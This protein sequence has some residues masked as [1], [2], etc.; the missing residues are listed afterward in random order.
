MNANASSMTATLKVA[1][2]T[3]RYWSLPSLASQGFPD[4][5]RLPRSIRV[6]LESVMRRMNTPGCTPETVRALVG[7]KPD[8]LPGEEIP[9][10]PSR[11]LLQ[12]FTGVPCVADL[13]ALR[14]ALH[15]RSGDPRRIEP[16]LPVDLVIDHSVQL[17]RAASPTAEVEN[18]RREFE[19]NEERYA[20]LR[21][22]QRA[23]QKLR[24]WPPGLG[25]C[26]QVNMEFLATVVATGTDEDGHAIAFPDTLVGTDSHTVMINSLGVM[27]WGVGG[28]EA[29]AAMLGQPMPL[30]A[31][32][33]TGVRVTGRLRL[34]ATATDAALVIT[35]MLRKK[36][37]VGH[38][39]EFFGPGLDT[40]NVFDRAPMANMAPEYGATMGFFPIDGHT[41]DYLRDTGRAPEQVALVEAYARAQGLWRDSQQPDPEFTDVVELNLSAIEPSVAGPKRPQD[42]KRVSQVGADF[43][44]ALV[45]PVAQRGFAVPEAETAITVAA[46]DLTLRHGDVVIASITSCTNTSN[47]A[48]LI[49]A[50]LLAR[51]AVARGLH[52]A[53]HVKTSFAPGSRVA[54]EFLRRAN[55]LKPLEQLGFHVAAFGCATCIGN[56]GPLAPEIE[57]AIRRG[58][59]VAAAVL[60]GNRNFEGRIHP[61]AKANYLCSPPLVV[62]YALRGTLMGDLEADPIGRDAQGRPV[63]LRDLLPTQEELEEVL[64]SALDAEDYR[65]IYGR[66]DAVTPEWN[67][68]PSGGGDVFAWNPDSTYVREPPFLAD[69]P[70]G[71]SAPLADMQGARCLGWFGDFITTDHIS[72]AGSIAK[73]SPAAKYLREHGVEPRDFNSYGARRGNHEV[74][75]RGTFANV[76]IR[77]LLVEREGGWTRHWPDGEELSMFDAAEKYRLEKIPLLVLAGKMYGAGSSRDWAAKGPALLGVRGVIAES[78]ERIHRSNLIGMGIVPMEFCDGQH[79]TSLGLTGRERFNIRGLADVKPGQHLEVAATR[80]DQAVT[81]FVVR[82]HVD[83]PQELAYLQ[84]GGILPYVLK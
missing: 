71:A 40:L 26:H 32:R 57:E 66:A 83:T 8:R 79:V 77:N 35:E 37:V 21:W 18:V 41:R 53:P 54:V 22:G 69:R 72:P 65:K 62:A 59:L 64:R 75:M 13:A 67:R 52:T 7:W 5:A 48:L 60:S 31:P 58:T 70:A 33:V 1:G 19:R 39:V 84:A 56:S 44:A 28:I 12:D 20:F 80:E 14:S 4:P 10:L 30:L 61:L 46:G 38:F 43:R 73:D 78:Y 74:M 49:A 68:L 34:P 11:V 24:V 16:I 36:G 6:L 47:P 29:E 23:F 17:D 25:I 50:A 3:Y 81:R 2:H 76:R 15:R 82:A 51:N 42:R 63:C 27:G 55:L 45:M 9:F